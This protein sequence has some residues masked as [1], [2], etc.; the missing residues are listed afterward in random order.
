MIVGILHASLSIGPTIV[1]VIYDNFFINGHVVDVEHQ[2]I[3]G[4]FA[5]LTITF[6]VV[7]LL[8]AIFYGCYPAQE[9]SEEKTEK[10]PLKIHN[11]RLMLEGS[12]NKSFAERSGKYVA[13]EQA[14]RRDLERS[15]GQSYCE[16]SLT[17]STTIN[18]TGE[19]NKPT[20][21]KVLITK[22]FQL[23]FWPCVI[24]MSLQMM[25]IQNMTTILESVGMA[26]YNN[27]FPYITPLLG[28]VC[29][30]AIGLV[31]DLVITRIPRS[32]FILVGCFLEI[33]A[34]SLCL[35]YVE[36]IAI[37]LIATS[38]SDI[39]SYTVLSL[40]PPLL[41]E[42]FGIYNF[43][44]NWGLVMGGFAVFAG[45]MVY[46][47]GVIY[48]KSASLETSHCFGQSC[49]TPT[50]LLCT[51]VSVIAT[52]SMTLYIKNEWHQRNNEEKKKTIENEI[53]TSIPAVK[54]SS[55]KEYHS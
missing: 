27:I 20:G 31:S 26:K 2:D 47:F 36:H 30:P 43:S 21:L 29:K 37:I 48:D 17:V 8:G 55:P 34:W 40:G 9:N 24:L 41:I 52:I 16:Q 54:W 10:S 53:P 46:L 18:V 1:M 12:H 4:F 44:M 28:I 14:R 19:D 22:E 5:F 13:N 35:G 33:L 45:L 6:A 51:I 39:A 15:L 23:V 38:A 7:N 32:T 49:F 25:F 3:Q 42:A 50:F 11:P